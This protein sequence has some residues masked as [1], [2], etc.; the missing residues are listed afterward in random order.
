[1]SNLCES[2]IKAAIT[3]NCDNP[4]VRG[5]EPDGVIINRSDIDFATCTVTGNIISALVLKTGKIGYPVYQMGSTPFTGTKV[6]LTTGTYRNKFQNEVV[7]AILDNNPDVAAKIIDGL[8]NGSFVVILRN[9]HKG[10]DGKAEYQVFGYYQG[11]TASAIENDKY[12]EDLDGGWLVTLQES[13]APTAAMFFYVTSSS[14]TA[15]AYEA[16]FTPASNS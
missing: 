11:L 16:L 4:I 5:L 6:T 3:A 10:T 8:A 7:I 2:L 12:S 13:N 14:A 15:T 1:M 9:R